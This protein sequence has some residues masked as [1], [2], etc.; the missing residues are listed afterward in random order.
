MEAL[1]LVGLGLG[2]AWPEA[3]GVG[4]GVVLTGVQADS[5]VSASNARNGHHRPSVVDGIVLE[6]PAD[7]AADRGASG[8][9]SVTDVGPFWRVLGAAALPLGRNTH[10]V[11]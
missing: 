10:E 5:S 7:R 3:A 1:P 6:P 2:L 4:L 8:A 9:R 11:N